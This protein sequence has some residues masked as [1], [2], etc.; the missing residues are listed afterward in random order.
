M[1]LLYELEKNMDRGLVN[2]NDDRNNNSEHPNSN[3][4]KLIINVSPVDIII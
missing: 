4:N 1:Y 3:I 2:D